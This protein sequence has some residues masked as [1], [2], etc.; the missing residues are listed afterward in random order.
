M[1]WKYKVVQNGNKY[2]EFVFKYWASVNVLSYIPALQIG[3]KD[4]SLVGADMQLLQITDAHSKHP[5]NS[6]MSSIVPVGQ[7]AKLML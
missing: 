7:S 1:E 2:L 4:W 5:V 3:E 6:L